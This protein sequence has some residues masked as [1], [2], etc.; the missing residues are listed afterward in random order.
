M[1]LPGFTAKFSFSNG[2]GL[3]RKTISSSRHDSAEHIV[4]AAPYWGDPRREHCN[5][6]LEGT[7][8]NEDY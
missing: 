3:Y 8:E 5:S 1:A 4:P 7:R 2:K 6:I